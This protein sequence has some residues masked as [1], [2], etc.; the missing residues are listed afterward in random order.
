MDEMEFQE[1]MVT[2]H[3]Q[4]CSNGNTPILVMAPVIAPT[5]VCGVCTVEITDVVVASEWVPPIE[6]QVSP[7][8]TA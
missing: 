6:E 1:Y 5:V 7:E 3:T 8:E 4:S 2:C